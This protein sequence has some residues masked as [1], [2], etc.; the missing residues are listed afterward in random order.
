VALEFVFVDHYQG[1]WG[2]I[3]PSPGFF[4]H[5]DLSK[6]MEI[7]FEEDIHYYTDEER[8]REGRFGF[9][10]AVDLL[11]QF[12]PEARPSFQTWSEIEGAPCEA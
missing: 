3:V 1:H 11:V 7:R 4:L 5:L 12:R 6:E 10:I 2:S 9:V 8:E